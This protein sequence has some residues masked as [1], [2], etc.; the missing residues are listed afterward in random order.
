MPTL[1]AGFFFVWNCYLS[2]VL[3]SW[4]VVY[5]AVLSSP[6]V[7]DNAGFR[8]LRTNGSLGISLFWKK[9]NGGTLKRISYFHFEFISNGEQRK[10]LKCY[11]HYLPDSTPILGCGCAS[12]VNHNFEQN[13]A[14]DWHQ[15]VTRT[16]EALDLKPERPKQIWRRA[17]FFAQDPFLVLLAAK[18]AYKAG[19]TL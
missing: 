10:N 15:W 5:F 18:L 17:A 2:I 1:Q 3:E 19:F 9:Q 4:Q 8:L 13:I 6:E 16:I 7:K 12:K 11:P 14:D